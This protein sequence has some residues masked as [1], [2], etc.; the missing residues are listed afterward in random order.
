MLPLKVGNCSGSFM[1]ASKG[2]VSVTHFLLVLV[3]LPQLFLEKCFDVC[4]FVSKKSAEIKSINY[5][6]V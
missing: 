2:Q 6:I 3:S 4:L 1:E 5:E